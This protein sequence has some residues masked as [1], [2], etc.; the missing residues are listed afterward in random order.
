MY[1]AGHTGVGD[2]LINLTLLELTTAE[3][4]INLS[5]GKM[6]TAA[7]KKETERCNIKDY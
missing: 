5:V 2:V 6:K 3:S 1:A 7:L 4:E